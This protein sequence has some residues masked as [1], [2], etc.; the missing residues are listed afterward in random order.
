VQSKMCAKTTKIDRNSMESTRENI[1]TRGRQTSSTISSSPDRRLNGCRRRRVLVQMTKF[2]RALS[3]RVTRRRRLKGRWQL[4]TAYG[5]IAIKIR[6]H[7]AS[8]HIPAEDCVA[9]LA[10]IFPT[11]N[12]RVQC[13]ACC[14]DR[15]GDRRRRSCDATV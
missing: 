11:S 6:K 12:G 1:T 15:T 5:T 13:G 14:Y 2:Q 10:L 7:A 8:S 9:G 3:I 4:N